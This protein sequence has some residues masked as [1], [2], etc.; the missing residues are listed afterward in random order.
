M[1][2]KNTTN[3]SVLWLRTLKVLGGTVLFLL[4]SV[5]G[6]TLFTN[7]LS[8]SSDFDVVY[9]DAEQVVGSDFRTE[10]WSFS[11]GSTQS[12][13]EAYSGNYSC[14]LD[15]SNSYGFTYTIEN[16]TPGTV[17]KVSAWKLEIGG[18]LGHLVV[19]GPTADDFYEMR[20]QPSEIGKEG[21]QKIELSFA[22][23][24]FKDLDYMKVYVYGAKHIEKV[25]FDDL[26]IEKVA[27]PTGT[28]A[29]KREKLAIEIDEK[30]MIKLRKKRE[31]ARRL[32]ILITD[33][34][35][36]VKGYIV[37]EERKI[38]IKLRLKGDWLDHL[39]GEKWSFRIQVKEPNAWKRLNTFSIQSPHTRSH[40]FEW[41][42][43]QFLAKE[44]VL[45]PRYDFIEL[46]LN[47]RPLG[48]Y[49]YEEH[50]DKN[51]L[52][53]QKRREGPIVRFTED[54]Y[55]NSYKRQI[56]AYGR[57]KFLEHKEHAMEAA[58]IAPYNSSKTMASPV[59]SKQ[60]ELAQTLMQQFRHGLKK[61]DEIF[62]L[63]L[64][65]KN[66]A[67]A[68]VMQAFH[69]LT[70]HNQRFYFNPVTSKL[71]PIGY[72]GF[73]EELINH[74]PGGGKFIAQSIYKRANTSVEVFMKAFF[75]DDF[76]EKYLF[77][78]KRFSSQKYIEQFLNE[79]E[80]A[81]VQRENF[82]RKENQ[83]YAFDRKR[84]LE[85]ARVLRTMLYPFP[86]NGLQVWAQGIKNG[87]QQLKITNRHFLPLEV[88]G[89]GKNA[90]NISEKLEKSTSFF[91]SLR[92]KVPIFSDYQA[93]QDAKVIFYQVPGTDSIFHSTIT[94]WKMPMQ[95]TPRQ[96]LFKNVTLAS[97]DVYSLENSIVRFRTGEHVIKEDLIIPE[98]YT[99]I[100]EGGS[101][102]NFIQGAKFISKS[103]VRMHGTE[104]AP[105]RIYSE[106]GTARGFTV[107]EP[108]GESILSYVSFE[109]FNTLSHEQWNL[110]GAVTFYEAKLKLYKCVF[111]RNNCEDALNLIR[112]DFE[113]DR[114]LVSETFAD[115]FDADFCTG[116]VKNSTFRN[117]GN[118]ALDFSTSKI[119]V[120]QCM[121]KNIGDKGIS[122]GEEAETTVWGGTI[123]GAVIGLA[124]KDLSQLTVKGINLVN[125]KQGFAAY[126]KKPEYGSASIVVKNYTAENVNQLYLIEKGST[127]DLK[128]QLI[129]N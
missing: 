53:Y 113:M 77:Y 125:C 24:Y 52:E 112:S 55:W 65:A 8:R 95:I 6:M 87:E 3:D 80:P 102:F 106:D 118:D 78:L 94:P 39:Q 111:T 11:N 28:E 22:V 127:L 98:N 117:T 32:G 2:L 44:D 61:P 47:G 97:N 35:D 51:L 88:V 114:C 90:S 17:Y 104:E 50:F 115:G 128:G 9:C 41:V 38:P 89:F 103:P 7:V 96:A 101:E 49:C 72:D 64:L 83:K 31:E 119:T 71:E 1:L 116:L 37:E 73:A 93:S 27:E 109:N 75:D 67:I 122:V 86:E 36:W 92:W 23:P 4:F 68:D 121:M 43:H 58:M 29:F 124:S 10:G 59:L 16:P 70:W 57:L 56:D 40:L 13:E 46:T 30:Q 12:N 54:D 126:Q 81:L 84:I 120:S 48:I 91:P 26:K 74:A 20:T 100:F 34:E 69:G 82:L 79:L 76:I 5:I 25:Y 105:I 60:F 85:R 63:D 66:Y 33:E 99:V 123:D 18:S 108:E 129:D 107:L 110:T 42:Y 45:Y 15:S 14:R 21:W 62:D 19:A